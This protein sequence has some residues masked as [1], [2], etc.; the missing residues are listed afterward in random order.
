[1]ALFRGVREDY[2]KAIRMGHLSGMR[3]KV[4][5]APDTQE[6]LDVTPLKDTKDADSPIAK[7]KVK[8]VKV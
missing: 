3:L 1:M 6:L 8:R 7:R 2:E 5:D 4:R